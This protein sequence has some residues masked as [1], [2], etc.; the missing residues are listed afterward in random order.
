MRFLIWL[1][2]LILFIVVGNSQSALAA[3]ECPPGTIAMAAQ[4]EYPSIEP[5]VTKSQKEAWL[6]DA[7]TTGD[8]KLAWQIAGPSFRIK[9]GTTTY[10]THGLNVDLAY[11]G[12]DGQPLIQ[13]IKQRAGH[14]RANPS[15]LHRDLS[16]PD[17]VVRHLNPPATKDVLVPGSINRYELVSHNGIEYQ[18]INGK[19][20]HIE[21]GMHHGVPQDLLV[22]HA[23]AT[24]TYQVNPF[25]F[26][27]IGSFSVN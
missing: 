24:H 9:Y 7:I 11:R 15:T 17:R 1:L 14:Y 6:L 12:V 20:Y 8:R 3:V 23:E 13:A 21:M 22:Y 19:L 16:D 10:T 18:K 2:L 25:A 27:S 26:Q 5:L 4:P